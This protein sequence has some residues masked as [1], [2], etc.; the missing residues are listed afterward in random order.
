MSH[1]PERH[2]QIMIIRT[3]ITTPQHKT[4]GSFI[5]YE[6]ELPHRASRL[7]SKVLLTPFLCRLCGSSHC[8]SCCLVVYG[9]PRWTKTF[10]LSAGKHISPHFIISLMLYGPIIYCSLRKTLW[11]LDKQ[12]ELSEPSHD[13]KHGVTCLYSLYIKIIVQ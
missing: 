3:S 1:E 12:T 10:L 8:R 7:Q 2:H 9:S 11:Y 6:D 13:H 4:S 5:H